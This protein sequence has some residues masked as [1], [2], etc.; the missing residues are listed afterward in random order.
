MGR[1]VHGKTK[2]G[3]YIKQEEMGLFIRKKSPQIY[4]NR[5]QGQRA[6]GECWFV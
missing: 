2:K 6:K 1:R 4:C 3:E 5:K